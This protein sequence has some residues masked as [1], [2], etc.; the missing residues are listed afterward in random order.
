MYLVS[1][2]KCPY[3]HTALLSAPKAKKK[4]PSCGEFIFVRTRP[5]DHQHVLVTG[6]EAKE[7]DAERHALQSIGIDN[8]EYQEIEKELTRKFGKP[9]LGGDVVWSA[10]NKKLQE[11]MRR[12][13]W[14]QMKMIYL[15]QARFLY[16]EGREFFD[17]LQQAAKCQLRYYESSGVVKKVKILTCQDCCDK[18]KAFEPRQISIKE[19]LN[20]LP[21]PVKDCG[22][23]FCRCSYLAAMD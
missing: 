21:I 20:S 15:G 23:G 7:I 22:N 5:S 6:E 12:S 18:C 4:C 16:E 19:A 17:V 8:K 1:E 14:H 11:A 13:D 9:P 3:C 2:Q 10:F